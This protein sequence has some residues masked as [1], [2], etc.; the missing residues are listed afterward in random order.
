MQFTK[1]LFVVLSAC[2]SGVLA[3]DEP[4]INCHGAFDNGIVLSDAQT[5]V[6]VSVVE[7]MFAI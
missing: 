2:L 7:S 3:Q 1:S 6:Q 5:A 4:V